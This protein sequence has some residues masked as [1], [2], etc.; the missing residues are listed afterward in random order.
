VLWK[1]SRVGGARYSAAVTGQPDNVASG[2]RCARR[3]RWASTVS[4]VVMV[5]VLAGCASQSGVARF[6]A[7]RA[8]AQ[9]SVYQIIQ[10][11][12]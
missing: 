3:A 1:R 11:P 6:A 7:V 9:E 2:G 4:V 8:A 10:E 12:R 5:A